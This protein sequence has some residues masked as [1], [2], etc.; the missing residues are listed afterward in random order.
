MGDQVFHSYKNDNVDFFMNKDHTT[1]KE[2]VVWDMT[3]KLKDDEGYVPL[4]DKWSDREHNRELSGM[5]D[6]QILSAIA[7]RKPSLME[8]IKELYYDMI[9]MSIEL[10]EETMTATDNGH[11]KIFNHEQAVEYIDEVIEIGKQLPDDETKKSKSTISAKFNE[12]TVGTI[13]SAA[14]SM[15]ENGIIGDMGK[16]RLFIQNNQYP[17]ATESDTAEVLLRIESKLKAKEFQGND[18]TN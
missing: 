6:Y 11:R 14:S 1:D 3:L 8:G 7:C 9:L 4:F 2:A 13:M 10:G 16:A 17:G 5:P 12:E 15:I 18:G